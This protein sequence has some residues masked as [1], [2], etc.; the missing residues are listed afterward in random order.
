MQLAKTTA[1]VLLS[2]MAAVSPLVAAAA[3]VCQVTSPEVSDPPPA[4]DAEDNGRLRITAGH[5]EVTRGGAASFTD[6][7]MI[8]RGNRSVTAG[9]A[10]YDPATQRFEVS[11]TVEYRDPSFSIRGEDAR[12]DTG[13]E[14]VRFK[15]AAFDLPERPARGSA[16][17]ISI[18]RDR[19][20]ELNEVAYTTCPEDKTDWQLLADQIRLD[21]DKGFGSARNVKLEF[22]NVPILA[23]PYISFPITE[24]RK[25]GLL[26]PNFRQSERTGTDIEVPYYLNLA[27]NYDLTLTPRI[28]TKRGFELSAG[29]RYLL[30][31]SEGSLL[32]QYLPNDS[33]ANRDRTHIDYQHQSLFGGGWR[34]L[35]DIESVSDDFYFE[36]LGNSLSVASRTHLDRRV[37]VEYLTRQWSF[38]AR[39]QD[40]QTIDSAIVA[41]DEPYRRLPQLAFKGEW[42][43]QNVTFGARAELAG[44]D[45]DVG[46]T[47]WR[48]DAEPELSARLERRGIF[49]MPTV[50]VRH[51]SYLLDNVAEGVSD[52]PNRTLP[53]VSVDTGLTLERSAGRD[54]RWTQTL[55]PRVLY[56]HVPFQNQDEIPIFDTIEPDFNLI[57][58]FRRYRFLGADRVADTDQLSVGVT[59][60]LISGAGEER[61]IA[62]L[63][64]TRYLSST[65]VTLP[66]EPPVEQER[67]DYIAELGV[68]LHETWN[69]DLGYQWNSGTDATTRAEARFQYRPDARRILNV[70]YRFRQGALEQ[71]DMSFAWPAGG[72]WSF[73]GRYNYS[74]R[75]NA[76]LERFAGVEYEAC[77]WRLRLVGRRYISRR[78]GES[79]SSLALQLELKGF[80]NVGDTADKLLERGI[81]GY[82][83]QAT[84]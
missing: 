25:S 39:V 20:V 35:T 62:T 54:G 41:E 29:F 79:D 19:V 2:A 42:A 13:E 37:D 80:T 49:F 16:E 9:S 65:G 51:T 63:G 32:A 28:L 33:E 67:S 17:E 70:A 75:E 43:G 14:E 36:D 53:M 66:G 18:G 12:Y 47:G 64:Q 50:S 59:T 30:P 23:L 34:L 27:P 52:N 57:Q 8:R 1:T 74:F 78:T 81:L 4:E 22:K 71:G 10:R 11:G 60:R 7:V 83:S 40:Y 26:I 77:C 76:N 21:V 61:L 5:A 82:Q 45:R 58:L 72:R 56:A 48:L 15:A 84:N 73:V 55:E 44:F 46:I 6:N 69:L 38:L 68:R 31:A 24:T 3:D